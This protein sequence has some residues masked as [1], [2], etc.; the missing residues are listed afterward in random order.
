MNEYLRDVYRESGVFPYVMTVL[1][2]TCVLLTLC[3]AACQACLSVCI[4][5]SHPSARNY[6]LD[7]T[8]IHL[9]ST[10]LRDFRPR[11]TPAQSHPPAKRTSNSRGIFKSPAHLPYRDSEL[12]NHLRY[13][14]QSVPV[15]RFLSRVPRVVQGG[16]LHFW[17]TLSLS[18][19]Q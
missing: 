14:K 11:P 2:S 12:P 19:R 5:I 10:V 13:K 17:L 16:G 7:L 3:P 6:F 18:T 4:Q 1:I 9:S 15:K 8:V